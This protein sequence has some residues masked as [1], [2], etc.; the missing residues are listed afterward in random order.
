MHRLRGFFS[1]EF[2]HMPKRFSP[3]FAMCRFLRATVLTGLLASPA[4]P[5]WVSAGEVA[6]AG[7]DWTLEAGTA[8]RADVKKLG[9]SAGL[10]QAAPLWQGQAWRLVLRHELHL[11]GWRV[12]QAHNLVEVGYSPV[13]RLERPV[14]G[15]PHWLYAE[16]SIGVRLLSRTRLSPSHSMGTAYHFAD[17]LGVGMRWGQGGRSSLG[18]RYQHLSNAGIKKPNP[19]INF[20]LLHYTH[21]F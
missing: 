3:T 20:V 16:A 19:G 14:G 8:S 21:R 12:P 7:W 1:T 11:A 15:G 4:L 13:L 17:M 2:A 18:V 6:P 9:L 5:T 10:T